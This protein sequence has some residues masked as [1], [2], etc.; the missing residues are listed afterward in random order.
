[1]GF[2]N[3][4]DYHSND[5]ESLLTLY[6]EMNNERKNFLVQEDTIYFQYK[7]KNNILLIINNLLI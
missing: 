3:K 4:K 1:M 6:L 2:I 7:K 5:I